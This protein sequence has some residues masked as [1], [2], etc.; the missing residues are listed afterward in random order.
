MIKYQTI[1]KCEIEDSA[2]LMCVYHQQRNKYQ[3]VKDDCI[4]KQEA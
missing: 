3:Q 2:K 4:N 1:G